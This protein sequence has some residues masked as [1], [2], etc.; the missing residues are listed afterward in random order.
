[1]K[2]NE[3]RSRALEEEREFYSSQSQAL[4]NSLQELTAEKQQAER[5]LKVLAEACWEQLLLR[6]LP[7]AGDFPHISALYCSATRITSASLA[8]QVQAMEPPGGGAMSLPPQWGIMSRHA[9]RA[10]PR[11]GHLVNG[12]RHEAEC[13][14]FYLDPEARKRT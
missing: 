9:P 7:S 4:Q 6:D 11:P 5:E 10:G 2:E 3:D 12:V 1:M 8:G 14:N 13:G